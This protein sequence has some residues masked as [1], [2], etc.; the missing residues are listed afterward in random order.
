MRDTVRILCLK[1]RLY[2]ACV[3]RATDAACVVLGTGL[4]VDPRSRTFLCR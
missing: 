4:A 1:S 2:I 3:G